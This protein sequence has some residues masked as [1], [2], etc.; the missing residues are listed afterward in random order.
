MNKLLS[1]FFI[2]LFSMVNQSAQ[3]Q[4]DCSDSSVQIRYKSF[5]SS[6]TKYGYDTFITSTPPRKYLNWRID[7]TAVSVS[8]GPSSLGTFGG[9]ITDGAVVPGWV[10]LSG[11]GSW[12]SNS[13]PSLK[14]F[15]NGDPI[16]SGTPDAQYTA[17][18]CGAATCSGGTTISLT[19]T[20][21]CN[22]AEI[23]NW[24]MN[25]SSGTIVFTPDTNLLTGRTKWWTTNWTATPVE[26]NDGGTVYLHDF[27]CGGGALPIFSRTETNEIFTTPSGVTPGT[28][29]NTLTNEYTTGRLRTNVLADLDRCA[30]PDWDH[31]KSYTV[32]TCSDVPVAP[33]AYMNLSTNEMTLALIKIM[34]RF[35]FYCAPDTDYLITW[36]IEQTF[37]DG[38]PPKKSPL[39]YEYRAAGQ[40][41]AEHPLLPPEANGYLKIVDYEVKP[42]SRSCAG[43]DGPS[44]A[45][46]GRA[47]LNSAKLDIDLGL[48]VFDR[49]VGHLK[50]DE[51]IL[52]ARSATP[53]ALIFAGNTNYADI[54]LSGSDLRQVKVPQA[55]VDITTN[56][57]SDFQIAFYLS[58]TV[59]TNIGSLYTTNGMPPYIYWRVYVPTNGTA[60][61][62][63]TILEVRPSKTYTNDYVFDGST[64][65]FISGNGLRKETKQTI[66][67]DSNSLRVETRVVY[68]SS[69][70][71]IYKQIEKFQNFLWGSRIIE[72]TVDPDGAALKDS[73]FYNY[74]ITN[75]TDYALLNQVTY[76]SGNWEQYQY[77]SSKR[78]T[79]I[80]SPFVNTWTNST[81]S[82]RDLQYDY[83]TNYIGGSGDN[84]S[85]EPLIP[86]R[87]RR[88]IS[89]S[90]SSVSYNL[91]FAGEIQQIDSPTTG[92]AWNNTNNLI[93]IRKWYT[94]GINSGKLLSVQNRN[95]TKD[96]YFYDYNA[97]DPV[98]STLRTNIVFSGMPDSS[99]STNIIAGTKTVIVVGSIGQVFSKNVYDNV[100]GLLIDQEIYSNHDELNR[101]RHITY[102]DGTFIDQSYDCC[103]ASSL[104]NRAGTVLSFTYDDLKRRTVESVWLAPSLPLSTI[105]SFD[106]MGN[107]LSLVRQG[108]NGSSTT[109]SSSGYDLASRL[110]AQ[111]NAAGVITLYTNVF[112]TSGQSIRT[113]FY[114]VGAA[115]SAFEVQVNARDG[116]LVQKTGSAVHPFSDSYVLSGGLFRVRTTKL[117]SSGAATS[118]YDDKYLDPLGRVSS[119]IRP[120]DSSS[121]ATTTYTY[122]SQGNLIKEVT[123][124]SVR[125]LYA[126]DGLGELQY[127]AIDMDR[128]NLIDLAGTDRIAYVTNDVVQSHGFTVF[129]TRT[130]GWLTNSSAI[131]NLL[132]CVEKSV[133]GTRSWSTLIDEPG[134]Q[135]I[136]NETRR[137]YLGN[138]YTSITEI[139]PDGS[140]VVTTNLHGGAISMARFSLSG[141]VIEGTSYEFDAHN[142]RY[143]STDL[144]N[145]TTTFTFDSADRVFSLTTPPPGNGEPA[146]STY[147]EY[148]SF[149]R[150]SGTIFPDGGTVTNQF[151]PSG[152]LKLTYGSRIYPAGYSY[153]AQ[154]RVRTMTNW[155]S[156]ASLSNPR[157]T[158]WGYN[159]WSG[160]LITKTNAGMTTVVSYGYGTSG[161]TSSR[162]SIRVWARTS[163]TQYSY[164]NAGEV[165]SI[166][167][168]DG[169]PTVTL[170]YDRAGRPLTAAHNGNTTT[171]GYTAAGLRSSE[172]YT[173]SGTLGANGGLVITNTYDSL[174]RRRSVFV[175]SLP[176]ATLNAYAYDDSS[177]LT[178]VTDNAYSVGYC[179][180]ANSRLIGGITSRQSSTVRLNST[181][182]YDHLNRLFDISSD[183]FGQSSTY[184]KANQRTRVYLADGSYWS[185][186]YDTLG[187]VTAGKKYWS[188]GTPVAGQQFE[189]SFDDIGNRVQTKAGGDQAG[190]NLR[191]ANYSSTT[192][193]TYT[194]RD[195]PGYVEVLGLA[196]ASATVTANGQSAY[197]HGEYYDTAVPVSNSS[198]AVYPAIVTTATLGTSVSATNHV[199]VP[200]STE[201]FFYDADG[202]LLSDGRWTNTW[203]CE[204]RLTQMESLSS[205]PVD[206]KRRL[207][208]E[209]DYQGRR[210]RKK[211][212]V[213]NSGT[214]S[215]PSTPASD[216]KF[217]YDGWNL[218]AELNSTNNA[219]IRSYIWGPDLSGSLQ[220]AGGVRG[221]AALKTADASGHFVAYDAGGNVSELVDASDGS[222]SAAY[223]YGPFGEVIRAT[224]PMAR[225]NPFRFSTKYFDD[226]VGLSY[227]GY[228]YYSASSGR[229][230]DRDPIEEWGGPNIYGFVKNR[231]TQFVD[232]LGL[233]DLGVI[234]P[235]PA[236]IDPAT[237][238]QAA[239]QAIK[240]FG[241]LPVKTPPFSPSGAAAAAMR[242]AYVASMLQASVVS[243]DPGED[244]RLDEIQKQYQAQNKKNACGRKDRDLDDCLD[245]CDKQGL[246]GKALTDCY[247]QCWSKYPSTKREKAGRDLIKDYTENTKKNWPLDPDTGRPQSVNHIWPLADGG[248][249]DW[250]N[251][252][253]L[254]RQDHVDLHKNNG[255][256]S[257]WGKRKGRT[258]K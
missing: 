103:N 221:L 246:Q 15:R 245:N 142:L 92:A 251:I 63:L 143:R 161:N 162:L 2:I 20:Q 82:S 252:E 236:V 137:A 178:N 56:S 69:G 29:V 147:T 118:E 78:I 68:D 110:I 201:S 106:P 66:W 169:T 124:D 6:R 209:Y 39:L 80:F 145:G 215:Y 96:V 45:G 131:S 223:E 16:F 125:T 32:N 38:T 72:R 255:D 11:S 241:T 41:A 218:L 57:P 21:Q 234:P 188:D 70:H 130:Y 85:I 95:G 194:S 229:W 225:V 187:Q 12:P 206:S 46:Q 146:Q 152:E 51:E 231:P 222:I 148:D 89:G 116:A 167:Y 227:Y 73:W 76:A 160:N 25:P 99:T 192:K 40:S 107:L 243:V 59:A 210:I 180:L 13:T 166:S 18:N 144:R 87:S 141:A 150:V 233:S 258:C 240:N 37:T 214:S 88:T 35:D 235:P 153:D 30:D 113:N 232:F 230:V 109:L 177:R 189:Y 191:A 133:D 111:T 62:N 81:S 71:V 212:F 129:R 173:G 54:L 28:Q 181:L 1:F 190:G 77:D 249:D 254:T 174:F 156:F 119:L 27:M 100:S 44:Y 83:G 139:S 154:G 101:P 126:Y 175:A 217:V 149:G 247:C 94:S 93:T 256:S 4:S 195:V 155:S 220:G 9:I 157:V 136:T 24:G 257:R 244:Q 22:R 5:S 226:E 170:T 67:T 183:A 203:N 204:N 117:D 58:D 228:R 31:G 216:L 3:A 198:G 185:Y 61:S 132:S 196:N 64:W 52:T 200:Q 127:K 219:V 74:A 42:V 134:S 123:P 17:S 159:A 19:I 55:L 208:F 158:A 237:D 135:A 253:P 128:N 79:H 34:Y 193:N 120:I 8:Y 168:S 179:Y 53:A 238:V 60:S 172:S 176:S 242:A 14:F 115:D 104:T 26:T 75:A 121:T 248:P 205:A 163:N 7:E 43:C 105:S 49:S 47:A 224:G 140:S 151:Y 90:E 36:K 250:K 165:S 207:Q 112:D 213:W 10:Q 239:S 33:F 86:R 211:V 65:T 114:A 91:V 182:S 164:N 199:F 23:E 186:Q 50:F 202:N 171:Y 197:R 98:N 97:A 48:A 138:G 184:D 122:D 102:L 108:T 84:A